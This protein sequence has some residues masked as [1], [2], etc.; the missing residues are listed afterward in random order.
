MFDT[1]SPL[2][3]LETLDFVSSCSGN[4]YYI[5]IILHIYIYIENYIYIYIYVSYGENEIV[6]EIFF[7]ST[8]VFDSY[9][10]FHCS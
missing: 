6:I 7:H 4:S 5:H 10:R 1:T 2:C 3:H 9:P 8:D